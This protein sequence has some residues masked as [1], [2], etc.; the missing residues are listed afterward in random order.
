MISVIFSILCLYPFAG[1]SLRS[2]GE[3]FKFTFKAWGGARR[4]HVPGSSAVVDNVQLHDQSLQ[5]LCSAVFLDFLSLTGTVSAA[6][7]IEISASMFI[8]RTNGSA[9]AEEI[10]FASMGFFLLL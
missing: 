1:V 4:E 3:R 8:S 10:D 6:W 2:R 5:D 9:G 7:W